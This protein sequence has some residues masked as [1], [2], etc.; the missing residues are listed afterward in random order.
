MADL[1]FSTECC[2]LSLDGV[3]GDL[4]RIAWHDPALEVISEPRLGE[5]FRILLPLPQQES[6]YFYSRDQEA[7]RIEADATGVTC[8]YEH[9]RNHTE[10]VDVRVMYRIECRDDGLEFSISIENETD[11]PVA[12]VMFGILGGVQG[13][14]RRSDTRS[15]I[16]GA[17]VNLAPNLFHTFPAGEYG[18]GNLGIRYSACGF[19]YSGYDGMSMSWSSF[20]NP[21]TG[22]GLYYGS[23][24]PETR[25]T[26][27]YLELRPCTS[28]AVPGSN[29]P[30]PADLPDDEPTGMTMGWVNFPFTRQSTVHLGPVRLQVHAGDWHAASA[31]YRSW[32][33]S[34]FTVSEA[35]WLRDEA[36]WQ[37]TILR[38]PEDVTVHCFE[39]L[40]A[41]AADARKYDVTTFEICGWDVGGIDRSYPDYRPD[42]ALGSREEFRTAL[43]SVR[44]LGVRP[45]VFA[46][47]Q[48]ADT[49]TEEFQKRLRFYAIRGRWAEDLILLG[50]GEGTLSA[51]MGLSRSNMAIM[52]LSHPALR[53]RLV[54]QMVDLVRDGAA[55]LQL[56]K[57]A[58]VQHLD[59]NDASPVSPDRSA[60]EGLLITLRE[61]L[62]RGRQIDPEFALASETWWDRTFQYINVMYSRMVDIDIP[63]PTLLYTFPEITSTVFAENPTDFNV[64]NN[65]MRYGMVWALAPRHYH[66]S[67]DERLTQPLARYVRELIR[68]RS[69]HQDVLFHGRFQ[70]TMGV[71]VSEHPDL[72]Y[73]VFRTIG[74]EPCRQACV[75]VNYGDQ[76]VNAIVTWNTS[77]HN[78]EICQPYHDDRVGALPAEICLSPHSCAVVVEIPSQQPNGIR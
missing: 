49:G 30:S 42:P 8:S 3:S 51:R 18:G 28:S 77:S 14:G 47:L 7:S 64:V 5:N 67:I 25:L 68:I 6:V 55:A 33:D 16:P 50:F 45:V 43:R 44:A 17:H 12:E 40:P 15:V 39:D 2:T 48:V 57:T 27:L 31:L 52:S 34:H 26:A 32:F 9:L 69:K 11:R 13:V 46:N 66:D 58:A 53:E 61:I 76:P 36:A 75:V 62:Q 23:H 71:Q 35:N 37:S 59:F 70:D 1:E 78:V 4:R 65:G 21:V 56:D 19:V 72:R 38:N 24:D 10:Q 20:Y 29:W 54:D 41:M 73:S 63:D 74:S 60:P 22:T